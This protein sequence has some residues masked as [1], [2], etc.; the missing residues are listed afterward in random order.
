MTAAIL[1]ELNAIES[2]ENIRI[3]L[4][5]ESGS[6]A[7][8]FASPDS[9][10]DVRFIYVRPKEQY[11]R[12][13]QFRD[14]VEYPISDLLD[15]NGWDLQKAL[16]LLHSSNPTLFEWFSSPVVYRAPA[17]RQ[18]I[19]PLL[20]Q[21]FS[22]KRSLHH[23]LNT[24]LNHDK[25]FL[26]GALVRSKKY[27]YVLRPLLACEWILERGTPPPILFRDLIDT[28]LPTAMKPYVDHLLDIKVN[29]PELKEIER[30]E[31][32]HAYIAETFASIRAALSSI[33]EPEPL[34]WDA[35]N[36]FFLTEISSQLF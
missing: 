35:L 9:D 16:R 25:A 11:L 21:Y 23:Y 8:G 32:L 26:Q 24:A 31:P 15:V 2:R 12:L 17:F 3:L 1:R 20:S 6:R 5:V 7:W 14:V 22:P 4:A 27:F 13:D 36:R 34:P 29:A 19:R 28:Q 30:I 18:D 33:S 10:Y